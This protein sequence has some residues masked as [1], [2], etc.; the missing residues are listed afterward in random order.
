M[1][2]KQKPKAPSKKAYQEAELTIMSRFSP[3]IVPCTNCR[4]PVA[5][6]Y[7]C[8]FCGHDGSE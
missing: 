4:W 7:V 2:N 1:K 5:V 3:A 6:G 8:S